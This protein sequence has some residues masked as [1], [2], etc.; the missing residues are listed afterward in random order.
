M[1]VDKVFRICY[2]GDSYNYALSR[3]LSPWDTGGLLLKKSALLAM[4]VP[5]SE[6]F[7]Y[8]GVYGC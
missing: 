7:F 2:I 4:W 6:G 8:L 3:K 1:R 5:P